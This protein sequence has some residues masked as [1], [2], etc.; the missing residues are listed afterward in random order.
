MPI[1]DEAEGI[2]EADKLAQAALDDLEE[3]GNGSKSRP[4][5]PTPQPKP[6]PKHVPIRFNP[7]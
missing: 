1:E 7:Y 6:A 4:T 2:I 3:L 5:T